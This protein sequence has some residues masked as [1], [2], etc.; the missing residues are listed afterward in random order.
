MEDL[1]ADTLST[2]DFPF[3]GFALLC[4]HL[5]IISIPLI[6][7]LPRRR[8][9]GPSRK[10]QPWLRRRRSFPPVLAGAFDLFLVMAL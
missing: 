9:A 2:E 6:L 4:H 1:I 5:A 10:Q 3:V 8:Q 7:V